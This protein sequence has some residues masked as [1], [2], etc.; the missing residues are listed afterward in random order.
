[1]FPS[2]NVLSNGFI[3]PVI[4]L[5]LTS[6]DWCLTSNHRYQHDGF[7]F[8]LKITFQPY[9]NTENFIKILNTFTKL[10]IDK[11]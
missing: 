8:R 11:F 6:C 4:E 3:N 1:M 2:L 5:N 10:K 7:R 9:E